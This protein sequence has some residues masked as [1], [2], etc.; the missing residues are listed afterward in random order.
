MEQDHLD[1]LVQGHVLAGEGAFDFAQGPG[2]AVG[3][4]G[5]DGGGRD[6]SRPRLVEREERAHLERQ[7]RRTGRQHHA[8]TAQCLGSVL[9]R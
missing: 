4:H 8:L 2:L 1:D 6:L 3:K 5:Q 9:G 7:L